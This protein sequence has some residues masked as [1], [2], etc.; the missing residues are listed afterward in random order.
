MKFT[1]MHGTGNDYVYINCFKEEVKNPEELARQI[2][3]RH[4][5]IGSD[6]LV[7]IMPSDNCDF[8]MRIFNPDGSE[9]EMCGNAARCIGKYV[10]DNGL[11]EKTE[12]TL[13][14]KAGIRKIQLFLFDN[15]IEKIRVDMGQPIL[16]SVSIPIISDEDIIIDH[17]VCFEGEDYR[18]TSVSMGN[19]HTVIFRNDVNNLL[20]ENVGRVIETDPMFPQRTNVEFVEILS[21]TH[22]KVR[23]WE[24]GVGE[25]Q[26]C[27]TGACAVL[28][29]GVLNKKLNRKST[30]SLP[31]G[32]LEIDWDPR[33]MHVYMTGN[34]VT[35]FNGELETE[36]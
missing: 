21:S 17:P 34:A 3:D 26:A 30:I 36:N 15:Q 7:L 8:R 28:V 18:I 2:S 19:P 29:A 23:V 9:A 22:A 25:T 1:K 12:I 35:I 16:D 5:G 11:T 20:L 31:G 27:G 33:N 32:D 10:F 14:T 13:E 4:T 24:R 6:G